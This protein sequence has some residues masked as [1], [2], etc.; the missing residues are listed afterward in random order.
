[1]GSEMCI[2]DRYDATPS[3]QLSL[4]V[5]NLQ[6]Q[7]QTLQQQVAFMTTT[8]EQNQSQQE[9]VN[10]ALSTKI[11]QA[12]ATSHSTALF[13]VLRDL[14]A[15]A[16]A[17]KLSKV[18]IEKLRQRIITA[19]LK[20]DQTTCDDYEDKLEFTQMEYDAQLESLVSLRAQAVSTAA[21][22]GTVITADQLHHVI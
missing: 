17:A 10:S 21:E 14:K 8:V 1:M 18:K 5:S 3:G 16:S 13:S 12:V 22:T 15:A 6:Q 7:V 20:G 9:A 2:R 11:D 19:G 4:F